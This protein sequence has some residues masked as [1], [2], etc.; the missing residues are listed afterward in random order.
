[1]KHILARTSNWKFILP[2]F[3]LFALFSFYVF[4][5]YQ[6]RLATAAGEPIRPLDTRFAY[7]HEDVLTDFEKLGHHGR[8]LY[9]VIVGRIDMVYPM[10]FGLLFLLILAYLLRKVTHPQ[11]SWLFL[12]LFPLLPVLFDYLENLNTLHLLHTFP[13]ITE[14]AVSRGE[15][16]TLLKHILGLVSVAMILVLAVVLVAKKFR[17]R[18]QPADLAS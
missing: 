14:E 15:K 8:I 3:L 5:D 4:P 16:F 12:A 17:K 10:I 11:S 13:N 6:S 2:F 18:K 7:T 1:M 9:T